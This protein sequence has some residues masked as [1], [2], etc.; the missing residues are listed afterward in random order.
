LCTGDTRSLIGSEVEKMKFSNTVN[1]LI[2]KFFKVYFY[3]NL[4]AKILVVERIYPLKYRAYKVEICLL[5]PVVFEDE[6]QLG[7][8]HKAGLIQGFKRAL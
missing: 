6:D 4:E 8:L 2:S 3:Q 5:Y 1:G 7:Q